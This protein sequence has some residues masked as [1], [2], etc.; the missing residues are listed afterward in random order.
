M[1]YFDRFTE[2]FV[3]DLERLVLATRNLYMG[4]EHSLRR[5]VMELRSEVLDP[6]CASQD[7]NVA[8]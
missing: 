4:T 8:A 5:P 7:N 2:K 3:F 6:R 1:I